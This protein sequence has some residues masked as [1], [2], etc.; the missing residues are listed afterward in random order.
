MSRAEFDALFEL[1]LRRGLTDQPDDPGG[2]FERSVGL[3][4]APG[5]RDATAVFGVD[6]SHHQE[7]SDG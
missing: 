2:L 4:A 5:R 6:V 1:D 7:L 3:L